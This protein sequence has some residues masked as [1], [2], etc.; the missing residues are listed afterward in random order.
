MT[1]SLN[2]LQAQLNHVNQMLATL[3]DDWETS[4]FD[5]KYEKLYNLSQAASKVAFYAARLHGELKRQE[6][7]S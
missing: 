4:D 6:V 1:A 7:D 3:T 5:R 2:D